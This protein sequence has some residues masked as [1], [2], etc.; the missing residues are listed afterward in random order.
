MLALDKV[1]RAQSTAAR[2][3]AK[4]SQENINSTLGVGRA[5][6]TAAAAQKD[7]EIALKGQDAALA[8]TATK[9]K[10]YS[11]ELERLKMKY[12]PLYAAS[13]QYERAL[14]D[15]ELAYQA[16]VI[17]SA[18]YKASVGS[19]GAEFTQ[20][21]NGT[22]GWSNQFVTGATR[23]GKSM[24]S[25]G[26]VTQQLGYQVGDFAVQ[27]QSG[28]SALVAFSQQATQLVG[29]LPLLADKMGMTMGKAIALSAALGIGI[30]V[31]TGLIGLFLATRDKSDDAGDAIASFANRLKAAREDVK[32]MEEDLRLMNSEFKN[33]TEL[34]LDDA[35]V[36][37]Q[38]K[39]NAAISD[40]VEMQA[41]LDAA[42][43]SDVRIFREQA[44]AQQE[45][46]DA[47]EEELAAA[48]ETREEY[49]RKGS[50]QDGHNSAVK[51]MLS[52]Q[53]ELRDTAWENMQAAKESIAD[54]EKVNALKAIENTYT[55]ESAEYLALV[56]QHE[57]EAL[58]IRIETEKL[59][60]RIAAGLRDALEIAQDFA[61]VDMA[62]GIRAASL[63]TQDL[64]AR[65]TMAVGLARSGALPDSNGK[66]YSGRG[67][68][69]GPS[70]SDINTYNY[71]AQLSQAAEAE[72][73]LQ[74]ELAKSSKAK[75][76]A[77]E[78]TEKLT[79]AQK[80]GLAITEKYL[81]P[82][83]QY[84]KG[85]GEL[86]VLLKKGAITSTTYERAMQDLNDTLAKSNPLVND[87]SNAFGDFV[88]GG[89]KDFKGFVDSIKNTF[90]EALSDMIATALRNRILIPIQTAMMGGSG[91]VGGI[92]SSVLGGGGGMGGMLGGIGATLGSLG[93]IAMG[94][95][96]SVMGAFASGGISGA[97]GQASLAMS[98]ATASFSG[99]A[100]AAG[101]AIPFIGA[102]AL[103]IGFF[104]TKTKQ[105]D[106]GIRLTANGASVAVEQFEKIK[107]S[108]FFGLSRK[109]ST[110]S[111]TAS[112]DVAN[113]L[114][115]AIGGIQ[116]SVMSM[117]KELGVGSDAF[118]RFSY[119]F[120]L[121]LKGLTEEQQMTKINEELI[122]MGD[123]F[124]AL[125]P[126]VSSMAELTAIYQERLGLELR[127]LQVQ[128]DTEALRKIELASVND[129]NKAILLQIYATEDKIA[130]EQR[131]TEAAQVAAQ[132]ADE[133]AQKLA[134]IASERYGLE[135]T[136]LGLQGNTNRLRQRELALLDPS[137]RALQQLIYKTEDKIAADEKAAQ[138]A[139]ELAD[140]LA[141]IASERQGLL[142][143]YYGLMKNTN[144]LR[145]RELALLDPSNRALQKLIYRT[146]D[147]I[148]ADEKAAEKAE[149]LA[150]KAKDLADQR[151]S[152]EEELLGLQGNVVEL[153]RREME[154]LDPT[155]R[156]L[157]MAIYKFEDM[158]K[159]LDNID[160]TKFATKFEYELAQARASNFTPSGNF[161][162]V[163]VGT[164]Q[165]VVLSDPQTNRELVTLRTTVEN[166]LIRIEDNTGQAYRLERK[167][168]RDGLPATRV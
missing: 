162:N 68:S 10:G 115:S 168:D 114:T 65:L 71:E 92:A 48:I 102:A 125:I 70:S 94:S 156:S 100:A 95:A 106:E 1:I 146:E 110:V 138:K 45:I 50:L 17:S 153:R 88:A 2:L 35:R 57:K 86:E 23:A 67:S 41:K 62:A 155:L 56:Q 107:R 8:R 118:S 59:T 34:A 108:R 128:G 127:L 5:S 16:G 116:S 133:L 101:A 112:A 22:A 81:T 135:T 63:A 157:Q 60:P 53:Q 9:T 98:G 120:K 21:Q 66:V 79:E 31:I 144:V 132:K 78:A 27:V 40:M 154:A 142:T 126:G 140:K 159:V 76:G 64:I 160:P 147:K 61:Q 7:F 49:E 143:E 11:A 99:F 55:K 52:L 15:I 130:A 158:Q 165:P 4:A 123:S 85:I 151:K 77:K 139:Q 36:A 145:S 47:A 3:H 51:D 134:A 42:G 161:S 46:V 58:E 6:R 121:S 163:N 74:A 39:L 124:A 12:Q 164:T 131:A 117:A 93:G 152:L 73:K 129:Y 167:W 83:E 25:M 75:K 80:A 90:K 14:Q 148:A 37:A 32:G 30:P 150:Q 28:Q 89:L 38:L 87:L 13:K 166:L 103:A 29:V 122:K 113:P 96:G 26:V 82:L 69:S 141:A 109:T 44:A 97:I 72:K 20:F 24:N 43:R 54:Q 104:K 91:G 111:R 84:N 33:T 137:N 19:L 119:S 105:L 18:Q 149:A 136:L